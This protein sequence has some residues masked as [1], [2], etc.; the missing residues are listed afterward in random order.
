MIKKMQDQIELNKKTSINLMN[1]QID[2]EWNSTLNMSSD[3]NLLS[4]TTTGKV[5]HI[6]QLGAPASW[7]KLYCFYD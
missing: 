1:G 3:D 4:K 2:E 5:L 7:S 6:M